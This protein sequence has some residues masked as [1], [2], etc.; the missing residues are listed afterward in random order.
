MRPL[1]IEVLS[2]I[3]MGCMHFHCLHDKSSLDKDIYFSL[4]KVVPEDISLSKSLL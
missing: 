4:V 3:T 2:C 1:T